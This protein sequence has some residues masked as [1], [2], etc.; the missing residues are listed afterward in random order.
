MVDI[1]HQF[2]KATYENEKM[3]FLKE[4]HRWMDG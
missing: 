2:E 3:H 4:V 1:K